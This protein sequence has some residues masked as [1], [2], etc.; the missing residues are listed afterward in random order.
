M[1]TVVE[2]SFP[3]GF[4]HATPW[5]HHVNEGAVEWPLSPWRLL[6]ALVA[7]WKTKHPD[8]D[9]RVVARALGMIA[10]PPEVWVAPRTE[11]SLRTY[12][13]PDGHRSGQAKTDLMIDAFAAVDRRT[14]AVAYRWGVG[15]DVSVRAALDSLVAGLGYLGRAESACVAAMREGDAG[16]GANE[17]LAPL[18]DREGIGVRTLVPATPLDLDALCVSIGDLRRSRRLD[19]PGARWVRYEVGAPATEPAPPPRRRPTPPVALRL[20]LSAPALPSRHAAVLVADVL[21][22]A[23]MSRF[24][25]RS[26]GDTSSRLSGKDELG[27][28]LRGNRHAHWL[29]LDDDGDGLLD[30]ALVW[31]PQGLQPAEVG[32]VAGIQELRLPYRLGVREFRPVR[33]A[34]EA[35]GAMSAVDL[36]GLVGPSD[37]WE[38]CSPFLPQRHPKGRA[39][40]EHVEDCVRRELEARGI[41]TAGLLVELIRGNW[42]AWRRYRLNERLARQRAGYGVRLTFPEPVRGPIAIG[43]LAH[44][45]LGLFVVT[46]AR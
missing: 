4:V 22:R 1:P 23:A 3:L 20:A 11:A 38:T 28:P 39:P 37:V 17:W 34:I 44:F 42:G 46:P 30:T 13:P 8:L 27:E 29:P 40:Q 16:I 7:V 32:A 18:D 21:R 14:P 43:S 24:G 35:L 5:Q 10:D 6:R 9:D 15:L 12:L 2:V 41:S 26:E 45:G 36:P 25:D 31:V 33:V 19:P